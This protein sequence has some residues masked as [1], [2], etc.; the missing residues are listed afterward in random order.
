MT[1][2]APEVTGTAHRSVFELFAEAKRRVGP[3]AKNSKNSQQNYSFRGIDAVVNAIAPHFDELGIITAPELIDETYATVE[4]GAKRTPMGHALVKVRYTFHGPKGDS[5]VAVT[6]GEAMD[7]GDKATPKAMS[8][9][10]RIALLQCLNLPTD[11]PDPD[12]QSYE[13]SDPDADDGNWFDWPDRI[14]GIGSRED[15]LKLDSLLQ[16]E[17]RDGRLQGQLAKVQAIKA[18]IADRTKAV[19][20]HASAEASQSAQSPGASGDS[21]QHPEVVRAAE[22]RA[23]DD[24]PDDA[25]DN[26]PPSAPDTTPADVADPAEDWKAKFKADLANA[27]DMAT[28]RALRSS[29]GQAVMDKILTPED[30]QALTPLWQQRIVSV[31]A[32]A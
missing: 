15:G 8:V 23:Q 16:A 28:I 22:R 30:S 20:A 4:V 32:A 18:A 12:S 13:R 11:E 3:V 10:Y 2:T 19:M 29:I 7:S 24:W 27:N 17:Y 9:A 26:I 5:F 25:P 1:Q 14:K 31:Q 21:Q 6:P